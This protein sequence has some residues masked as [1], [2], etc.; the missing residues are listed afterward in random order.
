M[1]ELNQLA[2]RLSVPLS[3]IGI[4]RGDDL[5]IGE[6]IRMDVDEIE[7]FWKTAIPNAMR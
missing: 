6:W 2:K 7:R 4:V 5:K 3:R 1:D